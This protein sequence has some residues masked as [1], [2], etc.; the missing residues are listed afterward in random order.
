MGQELRVVMY[1][2]FLAQLIRPLRVAF[3][4]ARGSSSR[5]AGQGLH[6]EPLGSR[7]PFRR[8]RLLGSLLAEAT[9][10]CP[11]TP[12]AGSVVCCHDPRGGAGG[13]TSTRR[14]P[15]GKIGAAHPQVR[16][17]TLRRRPRT[18]AVARP[19][20][21][22]LAGPSRVGMTRSIKEET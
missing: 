12:V 2:P 7:P 5:S 3:P 1:R 8:R 17:N 11:A 4:A 14:S 18:G 10:Q 20:R 15:R 22:Q 19:V 21:F 13:V 16:R 6:P 9:N